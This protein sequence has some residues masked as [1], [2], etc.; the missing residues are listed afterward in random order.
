MQPADYDMT[1]NS[2]VKLINSTLVDVRDTTDN[3]IDRSIT[4]ISDGLY[5]QGFDVSR[6]MVAQLRKP[7]ILFLLWM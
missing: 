7:P 5:M 6:D 2:V 1:Y 3:M 4:M